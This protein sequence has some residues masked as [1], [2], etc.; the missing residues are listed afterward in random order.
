[1]NL[2][3]A[4]H[5][6]TLAIYTDDSHYADSLEDWM[7]IEF[8]KSTTYDR[9]F[10]D[11]TGV[12]TLAVNVPDHD[13]PLHSISDAFGYQ[14][15]SGAL[16]A[17]FW[18]QGNRGTSVL[19]FHDEPFLRGQALSQVYARPAGWL[20]SLLLGGGIGPCPA[21]AAGNACVQAPSQNLRYPAGSRGQLSLI[22]PS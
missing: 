19:H 2:P 3:G 14:L 22:K 13:S 1:V 11:A 16:D 18:H 4:F 9:Q 12:G 17:V 7:P 5:F 21:D 6:Y 10:D 8:V 20:G 15:Q